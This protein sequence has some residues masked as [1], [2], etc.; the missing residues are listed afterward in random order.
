MNLA[1]VKAANPEF[2]G[3]SFTAYFEDEGF[4]IIKEQEGFALRITS[5]LGTRPV[6]AIDPRSLIL[7]YKRHDPDI[8][9]A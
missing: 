1:Q 6:Y 3:D 2:F 9:H 5:T 7:S 4:E 8:R